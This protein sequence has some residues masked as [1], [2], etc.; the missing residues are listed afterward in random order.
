MEK[1]LYYCH[2]VTKGVILVTSHSHNMWQGSHMMSNMRTVEDEVYS[3]N[4]SCIYSVENQLE[5]LLSFSCQLG[6]GEWLSCLWLNHYTYS[7]RVLLWGQL[8]NRALE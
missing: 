1:E 4:S 7:Q 6:L 3:H 5:T 2:K 8:W